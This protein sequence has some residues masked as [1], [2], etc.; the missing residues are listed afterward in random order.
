M[1]GHVNRAIIIN[2]AFLQVLWFAAILGA[3][4]DWMLPA[5]LLFF[6]F[7]WW[8]LAAGTRKRQDLSIVLVATSAGFLLDTVWV[9][10]GGLSFSAHFFSPAVAPLCICMLWAGLGLTIDHSLRWLQPRPLMAALF[11]LASAPLSYFAAS[12]LGAVEII[13]PWFLYPALSLSWAVVIPFLLMFARNLNQP[14]I[15]GQAL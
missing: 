5:A 2:A 12:R 4:H 15:I 13:Q 6:G 11:C 8:H 7:L 10:A 14:R 1:A 9:Q 3:A